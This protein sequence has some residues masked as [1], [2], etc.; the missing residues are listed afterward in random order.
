MT[1]GAKSNHTNPRYPMIKKKGKKIKSK[2]NT[3][4]LLLGCH[5][6]QT[7]TCMH[8]QTI[9]IKTPDNKI[10]RFIRLYRLKLV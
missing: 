4:T 7:I 5:H 1:N 3:T 6:R 9:K 2:N 8:K 10:M